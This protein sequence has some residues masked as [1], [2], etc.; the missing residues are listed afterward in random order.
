MLDEE[1]KNETPEE[2]STADGTSIEPIVPEVLTENTETDETTRTTEEVSAENEESTENGDSKEPITYAF[3]WDYRS[4]YEQE[5]IQKKRIQVRSGL[6][7]GLIVTT[8]FAVA[9][10]VLAVLLAIGS[11]RAFRELSIGTSGTIANAYTERVVYVSGA[12]DAAEELSVEQAVAKMLPSAVSIL[13]EKASGGSG[14][15]S[16]VVYSSDGY[17]VT[18][19][20]VIN[21]MSSVTVRLYGGERYLAE[22]VGYDEIADLAL[23]KIDATGLTPAVFG[24]SEELLV[25]E[26][27]MAIGAPTGVSYSETVTKGIVSCVRRG[28][29]VYDTSG[30]L[31]HTLLMVQ[32]DASVNPGNSGGALFSRE[33]EVVGIVTNK[34]IFYDNGTAYY[35]DGMGLAIPAEAVEAIV[36]ALRKGTAPDR[37]AFYVPA[38]RIGITGRIETSVGGVSVEGFTSTRFDAYEKLEIGDVITAVNGTAVKSI[39]ELLQSIEDYLPGATV[40]LTVIRD[41]KTVTVALVL[42]S[43]AL[44]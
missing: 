25:G 35:A 30:K 17:I 28:V 3:R 44:A 40:T 39:T 16:G 37:T 31:M 6:L 10:A 34:T 8:I 42:G 38:A 15:G 27:V 5:K 19:H 22:V 18:N 13:V 4:Q 36:S 29:K 11:Y 20:H 26:T 23:L 43:D 14:I 12:G 41:G 24:A 21:G 9:V 32:T 7:Y 1:N 33:G 2:A